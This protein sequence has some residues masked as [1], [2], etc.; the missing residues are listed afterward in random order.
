MKIKAEATSYDPKYKDYFLKRENNHKL[1]RKYSQTLVKTLWKAWAV[2]WETIG[3]VLR[4]AYC[5]NAVCL[6]DFKLHLIINDIRKILAYMLTAGNVDDRITVFHLSKDIFG[7]LFGDKEY[8][9]LQISSVWDGGR[10]SAIDFQE[11][12][13]NYHK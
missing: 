11:W 1:E 8:S 6:I 12:V 4:G 13:A 3:T 10:S 2:W 5:S 9:V 7:K